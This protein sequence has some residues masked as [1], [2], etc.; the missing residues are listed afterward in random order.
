MYNENPVSEQQ[1][2][3]LI[4]NQLNKLQS[5]IKLTP[6]NRKVHSKKIIISE[7]YMTKYKKAFVA[8][9]SHNIVS[10]D[11]IGLSDPFIKEKMAHKFEV[12]Q[13]KDDLVY[14]RAK[15][16]ADYCPKL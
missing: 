13:S 14:D 4:E 6:L 9:G 3:E 7:K 5:R 12:P 10:F 8:P 1:L 2:P 11:Q 16:R 15:Y